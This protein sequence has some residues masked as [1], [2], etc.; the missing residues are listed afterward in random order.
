MSRWND[1]GNGDGDA[2]RASRR[3]WDRGWIAK[4]HRLWRGVSKAKEKGRFDAKRAK[5]GLKHGPVETGVKCP[6]KS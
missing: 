1:D 2:I 3:T 4:A 5:V 6:T